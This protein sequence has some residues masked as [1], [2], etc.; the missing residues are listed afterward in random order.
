M[1]TLFFLFKFPSKYI[2]V[3]DYV[4]V[5]SKSI[6]VTID[7]LVQVSMAFFKAMYHKELGNYFNLLTTY[8]F[9]EYGNKL[10]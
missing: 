7:W 1:K 10:W 5:Y 2:K 4:Y 8:F 3:I 9:Q 6:F